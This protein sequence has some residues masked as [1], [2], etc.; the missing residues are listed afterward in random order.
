M[1]GLLV[2]S[3][4]VIAF[5]ND[6]RTA[7]TELLERSIGDREIAVADLVVLEI[8]QG[9]RTPAEL[10]AVQQLLLEFTCHEVGGFRRVSAAAVNYQLLRSLG[11]T[12]RSSSDILIA[13]FCIEEGLELLADDRDFKLMAPHLG[14]SLLEPSLN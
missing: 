3:S 10:R 11:I 5:L 14:L 8:L 4:V 9:L 7:Y 12:P 6:R 1:R 13:T 2:D